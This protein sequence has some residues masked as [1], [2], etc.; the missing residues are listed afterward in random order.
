MHDSMNVNLNPKDEDGIEVIDLTEGDFDCEP[1]D[2][3]D[4]GPSET[5]R[6]ECDSNKEEEAQ[7]SSAPEFGSPKMPTATEN[8]IIDV[9]QKHLEQKVEEMTLE[10]KKL[11]FKGAIFESSYAVRD[12]A[13]AFASKDKM[14]D[15]VTGTHRP[16]KKIIVTCKHG[17]VYRNHHKKEEPVNQEEIDSKKPRKRKSMKTGCPCL[18]LAGV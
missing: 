8:W 4:N 1:E 6:E 2:S 17:G 14:M 7:R 18:I 13:V 12:A 15:M 16:P 9:G 3:T 5:F 11:F 10:W